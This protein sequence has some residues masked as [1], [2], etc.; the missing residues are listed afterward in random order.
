MQH[1]QL[2]AMFIRTGQFLPIPAT[3]PLFTRVHRTIRILTVRSKILPRQAPS[4]PGENVQI[5]ADLFNQY[6]KTSINAISVTYNHPC[7]IVIYMVNTSH[8]PDS[9]LFGLNF[10]LR[11]RLFRVRSNWSAKGDT[12]SLT[13]AV[14]VRQSCHL[15]QRLTIGLSR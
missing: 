2:K 5:E 7:Q 10:N 11:I 12:N 15:L 6:W 3:E 14:K 9:E 4:R 8:R 13:E 1:F